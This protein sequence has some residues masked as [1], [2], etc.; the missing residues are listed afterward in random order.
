MSKNTFN[1]KIVGAAGE[2]IKSTGMMLS[3]TMVRSGLFTFDYTEYPSLIRGG[4]NTYQVLAGQEKVYSQELPL[5]VLISLNKDSLPLHLLELTDNSVLIYD[6]SDSPVDT[7]QLKI[8]G[9]FY[10]VPLYQLAK[11]AGGERVMANNVALGVT[12]GLLNFDLSILKQVIADT[13]AGKSDSVISLNQEAAEKGY[14]YAKNNLKALTDI[15]LKVK[16]QTDIH[17]LTGNEALSLGL[18][19]GGLKAYVAYPMTPSSS[20]LHS[21]ADWQQKANIFVKHAEDEIGVINMALGL[22][23]A[24]VRAAVGT[25]GGGFCYMT[26]AVGLAGVAELP[27]VIVESQRPGPALGMPTWT[28]QADLLFVINASQDEFPRIVLAPGDVYEAFDLGRLSLTLAEDYQLPVIILMD[29][30]LS[31]S[32]MSCTLSAGPFSHHQNS[33]AHNPSVDDS[34][35]FPRYQIKEDLTGISPRTIPGTLNGFY[36]ANSY[37]HDRHGLA[38][39]NSKDRIAQMDKRMAKLDSLTHH[40]PSQTY[41]SYDAPQITFIGFGSTKLAMQAAVQKLSA[42]NISAA[43]LNLSWLWPFP[44]KQVQSLLEQAV[45]PVIIEGNH[46]HQLAKLICQ[47]TGINVFHK[48]TKYDGRPFYPEDLVKF[49]HEILNINP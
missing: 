37:E 45:N 7:S 16:P 2:G 10:S 19:A 17:T 46:D 30:H 49:A 1:W 42:L 3:K 43:F 24:G 4:H 32:S 14:Q 22:S 12:L 39:E 25:S 13:F 28:A 47:E 48:R 38:S 20:I 6:N 26:E 15:D 8:R 11:E 41:F 21:L 27:L 44:R 33:F 5:D 31:E 23:Y 18:I 9:Q 36:C 29:K 35:F 40:I 34:G